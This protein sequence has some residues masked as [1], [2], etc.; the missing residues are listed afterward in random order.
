MEMA[1]ENFHVK[2]HSEIDK[3]NGESFFG[4]MIGTSVV[5]TT[6]IKFDFIAN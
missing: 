1:L 5:D 6:S 4:S 3:R 2:I